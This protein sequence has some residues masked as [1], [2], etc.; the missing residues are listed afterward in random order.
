[1][2]TGTAMRLRHPAMGERDRVT[3]A[4]GDDKYVN[5]AFAC[6]RMRDVMRMRR[7]S[8]IVHCEHCAGTTMAYQQL[9]VAQ[10][11]NGSTH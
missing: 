4:V 8:A 11:R 10:Q 2:L 9:S 5:P 6:M 7:A 3:W 1:V